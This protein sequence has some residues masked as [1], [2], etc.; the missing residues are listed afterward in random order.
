MSAADNPKRND[1]DRT[2]D[3]LID[4][5][6]QTLPYRRAVGLLSLGRAVLAEDKPKK[7]AA[8]KAA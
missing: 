4:G 2:I 6:P 8:K 1:S 3:V 5:V 7:R